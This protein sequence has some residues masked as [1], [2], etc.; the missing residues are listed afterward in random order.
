MNR[1]RVK[2]QFNWNAVCWL[3]LSPSWPAWNVAAVTE[4][5]IINRYGGKRT[6]TGAINSFVVRSLSRGTQL[7]KN[8]S[9]YT[10]DFHNI[11]VTEVT[12]TKFIIREGHS[13]TWYHGFMNA[14]MTRNLNYLHLPPPSNNSKMAAGCFRLLPR[15]ISTSNLSVT[16]VTRKSET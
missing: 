5:R 4:W 15:D 1:Q 3:F 7:S 13:F 16:E 10:N 12:T 6:E 14:N 11:M 2:G 9:L 8:L